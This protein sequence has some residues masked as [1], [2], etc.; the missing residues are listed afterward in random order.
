[1]PRYHFH[2]DDGRFWPDRDGSEYPSAKVASRAAVNIAGEMLA[3]IDDDF[4]G[5]V[6]VWEMVVTDAD[7]FVLLT[8]TFSGKRATGRVRY[9]PG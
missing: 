7:G 1:M 8:L 4:W 2:I 3:H 6:P 5:K 9:Q